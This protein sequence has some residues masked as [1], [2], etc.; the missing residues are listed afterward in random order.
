MRN[1]FI[2]TSFLGNHKVPNDRQLFEQMPQT[3]VGC[4]MSLKICFLHSYMDFLPTNHG[5]ISVEHREMLHQDASTRGN[6][7]QVIIRKTNTSHFAV[8][9]SNR[10]SDYLQFL[11]IRNSDG[12]NAK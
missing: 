10:P 3:M 2:V 8:A 5:D 12:C 6:G 11:M 9:L 1:S 4:N 7:I